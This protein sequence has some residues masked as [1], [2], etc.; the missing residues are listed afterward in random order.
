MAKS[1]YLPALD[2]LRGLSIMVVLL[3]HIGLNI[4]GGFGVNVFFFISGL[5]ITNLLLIE[6]D[7]HERI[8]FKNF[9]IRRL[10]RLYPPLLLMILVTCIVPPLNKGI[11]MDKVWP[12]LFYYQNYYYIANFEAFHSGASKSYFGFIWSLA[13][14]EHFYLLFPFLFAFLVKNKKALIGITVTIIVSALVFRLIG[15]YRYGVNPFAFEYCYAA[16]ECRSD[17]IMMGCLASILI[18]IDRDN[19]FLKFVSSVPVFVIAFIA[20]LLSIVIKDHFFKQTFMYTIQS[21]S[22]MIMIP[23]ILYDKKYEF[24]NRFFS[25][26]PLVFTGRLSY[27]LYLFHLIFYR[28]EVAYISNGKKDMLYY[29]LG[30]PGAFLLATISYYLVEKPVMGLRRKFGSVAGKNT[31]A[32]AGTAIPEHEPQVAIKN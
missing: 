29:I 17:A 10:L 26:K 22:F 5:L 4:P 24:L 7:K 8:D 1:H 27:S 21:L 12:A 15:T 20:M 19:R 9:F 14:E 18:Y 16:T 3:G 11:T 2:G 28:L 31:D 32:P 25:T 6:Y 13:I 30:I 23:A